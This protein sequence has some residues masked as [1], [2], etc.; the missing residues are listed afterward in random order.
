MYLVWKAYRLGIKKDLRYAKK[1]N[2]VPYRHPHGLIRKIAIT[3]L[4]IGL[5]F[6]LFAIAIPL[7]KIKFETWKLFVGGLVLI[8]LS[9]LMGLA[10][11]DEI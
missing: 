10:R 2:G 6:I 9:I 1:L 11:K 7:L 3:D 8:R 5:A 4:A